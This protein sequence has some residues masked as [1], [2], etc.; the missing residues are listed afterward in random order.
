MRTEPRR[1]LVYGDSLTYGSVPVE[2]VVPTTRYSRDQRWTGV[3]GA[4][5]GPGYEIIE[6]GLGGRTTD[7][8]DR[9]DPLRL[10]GATHLPAILAS[11]LPLDLVVIMLGTNDFKW[12]FERQPE[13]IAVGVGRLIGICEASDRIVGTVYPAPQ[14]LVIAP[15]PLGHISNPW[16]ARLFAG[17]LEKSK[18]YGGALRDLTS[19]LG[20]RFL[21]AAEFLTTD[22]VD[23]IHFTR[24]NNAALGTAVAAAVGDVF[25]DRAPARN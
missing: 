25:A 22:G 9:L 3:L 16:A 11:H 17:G 19:F 2:R 12:Y 21:D 18:R 7:V 8:D 13:D 4:R 5:L 15:P 10:N 20:A 14:V 24:Q 23:G 6:E 1:V